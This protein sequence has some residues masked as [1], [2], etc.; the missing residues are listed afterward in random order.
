MSN[1]FV[2]ERVE[3]KISA[4]ICYFYIT[5]MICD[6]KAQHQVLPEMLLHENHESKTKL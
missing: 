4:Y 1:S 2:F 6:V 5:I 3:Q